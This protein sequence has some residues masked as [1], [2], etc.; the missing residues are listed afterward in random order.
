MKGHQLAH[1]G[2]AAPAAPEK[3]KEP[4]GEEL[5]KNKPNLTQQKLMKQR[6]RV[7]SKQSETTRPTWRRKYRLKKT[8]LL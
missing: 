5:E 6:K 2:K 1:Q 8:R 3:D 7:E 4:A